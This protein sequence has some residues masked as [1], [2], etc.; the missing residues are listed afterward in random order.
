MAY[1]VILLNSQNFGTQNLSIFYKTEE[2]SYHIL[3]LVSKTRMAERVQQSLSD[4]C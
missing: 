1:F 4:H 2:A 3:L